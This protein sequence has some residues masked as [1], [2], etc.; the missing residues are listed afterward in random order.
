MFK[1][2]DEI[3]NSGRVYISGYCFNYNGLFCKAKNRSRPSEKSNVVINNKSRKLNH[4]LSPH[5]Y[6]Y[7][8]RR[9]FLFYCTHEKHRVMKMLKNRTI[10]IKVL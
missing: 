7:L 2:K 8:T 6:I 5:G 3:K 10:S 9:L 4:P 1:L